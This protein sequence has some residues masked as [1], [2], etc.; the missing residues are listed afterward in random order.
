VGG[1][2]LTRL[3]ALVAALVMVPSLAVNAATLEEL[4][5]RGRQAAYTAEQVISCATPDGFRG[6]L[7]KIRQSGS[8][9]S[10]SSPMEAGSELSTG[11]GGWA[12]HRDGGVVEEASLVGPG[13]VVESDYMVEEMGPQWFMGRE[14]TGFRLIREGLARAE[15]V[16]DDDTGAIV[17]MVSFDDQGQQYCQRRFVT[18][19]ETDPELPLP[20]PL[21]EGGMTLVE[22]EETDLPESIAGFTLLDR[23]LDLGG[24]HLAYYSDGLFS[25]AL[26]EAPTRVELPEGVGVLFD[27]FKY[28]R[29]FGAGQ[30]TYVWEVKGRGMALVGD[31]PPDLHQEVL[32]ALPRPV[33]LGFLQR[34]WRNLFGPR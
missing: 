14:A 16:L 9:L 32:G 30:V 1:D 24:I 21:S 26:F 2:R 7:T 28:S 31:L 3:I 13:R 18:F 25:F 27:G 29:I 20:E 19:D 12:L 8:A 6:V 34:V 23:Y 15:L 17:R 4:L 10:I 33:D 11:A 22:D 5:E